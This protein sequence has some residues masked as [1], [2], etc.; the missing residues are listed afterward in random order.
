MQ[1]LQRTA[2]AHTQLGTCTHTRARPAAGARE[3]TQRNR[4][5]NRKGQRQRGS[6]R[7]TPHHSHL[8]CASSVR[9]KASHQRM[10]ISLRGVSLTQYSPCVAR[11]VG[12]AATKSLVAACRSPG[13]LITPRWPQLC[14]QQPDAPAL[15][16]KRARAQKTR[17]PHRRSH[18]ARQVLAQGADLVPRRE[19]LLPARIAAV[20]PV[21][22]CVALCCVALRCG[23]LRCVQPHARARLQGICMCVGDGHSCGRGR[24]RRRHGCH[25]C[26]RA[27]GGRHTGART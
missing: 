6:A 16:H 10:S 22:R 7:A 19:R 12:R 24:G 26:V 2:R 18:L 4:K 27:A 13:Q 9:L 5:R 23:A 20:R 3:A 25:A 21:A 1:M 17:V 15:T 14:A 11:A 8:Q